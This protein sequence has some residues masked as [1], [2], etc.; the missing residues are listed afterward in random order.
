MPRGH[1]RAEA[2]PGRAV[3]RDVDRAV[4]QALA[5]V[6]P[7]QL[8]AEHRADRAVHVADR[9]ARA[10]PPSPRSSAGARVG[11]QLVVERLVEP[12]VLAA[13]SRRTSGRTC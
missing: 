7:R 10:S 1:E 5:A 12:V 4:G 13:A 11:D 2:L 3:E 9:V 6:A 8:G